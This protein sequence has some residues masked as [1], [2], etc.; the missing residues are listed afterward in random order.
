MLS[1][2][3]EFLKI[4]S[5]SL[6]IVFPLS[7]LKTD[8]TC[9]DS[10]FHNS[11]T[12]LRLEWDKGVLTFPEAKDHCNNCERFEGCPAGSSGRLLNW[13]NN[14]DQAA[15]MEVLISKNIHL[16]LAT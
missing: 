5:L 7:L 6:L 15:A 16:F 11:S 12:A 8:N 13:H 4:S 2:Y 10:D 1:P 14:Q 9:I 3:N